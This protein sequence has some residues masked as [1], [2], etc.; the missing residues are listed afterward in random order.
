MTQDEQMIRQLVA[1]FEN[2][3]NAADGIA[4]GRP[5]AGNADFTAVTGLRARGRDEI[6]RGHVEILATVFRGTHMTATVN[7]ITFLRPDVAA[8]DITI[9]MQPMQDKPWLPDHASCGI[10]ATKE[11]GAWAIAL[12]RNMVPFGRP[13]SGAYEAGLMKKQGLTA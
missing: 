1:D 2:G 7:D 5:F 9:R 6:A 13:I 11:D 3:W 8:A 10:V 12:F 4:C